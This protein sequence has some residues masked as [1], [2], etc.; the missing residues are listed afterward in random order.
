MIRGITTAASLHEMAKQATV[1]LSRVGPYRFHGECT[2]KA[3]TENEMTCI[4]T[5]GEPRFLELTC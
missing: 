5:S 1:V 3:R 2:V 4:D